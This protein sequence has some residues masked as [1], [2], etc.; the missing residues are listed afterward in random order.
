VTARSSNG[1]LTMQRWEWD[2]YGISVV[3]EN[4]NVV[5]YLLYE[6]IRG[7]DGLPPE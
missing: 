7:Q 6:V 1:K 3:F 5:G 2:E 4:G